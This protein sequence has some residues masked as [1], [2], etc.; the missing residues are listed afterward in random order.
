MTIKIERGQ[1]KTRRRE[2]NRQGIRFT[3]RLALHLMLFLAA[4]LAGGFALVWKII[5]YQLL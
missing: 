2:K 4:G 1:K 3:N 5:E